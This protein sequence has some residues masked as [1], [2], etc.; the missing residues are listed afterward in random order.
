MES[1]SMHPVFM[2]AL[3]GGLN[4]AGAGISAAYSA[5]PAVIPEFGS[6]Y[7]ALGVGFFTTVCSTAATNMACGLTTALHFVELG[8]ASTAV[9]TTLTAADEA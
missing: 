3:N 2:Q 4:G 7:G 6:A 1:L 8:G 9:E 5:V